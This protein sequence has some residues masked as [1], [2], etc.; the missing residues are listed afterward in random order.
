MSDIECW[1]CGYWPNLGEY[2]HGRCPKCGHP[3]RMDGK[4]DSELKRIED[5][6]E[7]EEDEDAE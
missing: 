4:T 7:R 5:W 3:L 2:C 6:K 1:N